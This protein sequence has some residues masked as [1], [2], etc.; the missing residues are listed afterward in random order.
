MFGVESAFTQDERRRRKGKRAHSTPLSTPER[1]TR[2]DYYVFCNQPGDPDRPGDDSKRVLG[3]QADV[4]ADL[5]DVPPLVLDQAQWRS[6]SQASRRRRSANKNRPISAP[7]SVE[8]RG[9]S[10]SCIVG[11]LGAV[12]D[13]IA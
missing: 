4:I 12:V 7:D 10:I 3:Q 6:E 2:N 1:F 8:R 9:P 13:A 5:V 11:P